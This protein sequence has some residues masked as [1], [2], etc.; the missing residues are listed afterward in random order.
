VAAVVA[1]A[2]ATEPDERFATAG[3]LA[4]AL[5]SST[6]GVAPAAL[7]TPRPRRRRLTPLGIAAAAAVVA[8][9]AAGTIALGHHAPAPA[10]DADVIAVAP[11]DVLDPSLAL[12]KEGMVDVLSRTLDG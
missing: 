11:F 5:D 10:L 8:V 12:W 9:V 1:R 4:A 7:L 6:R 3:D 2:M